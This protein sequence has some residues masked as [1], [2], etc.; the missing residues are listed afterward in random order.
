MWRGGL[1][2]AAL[3]VDVHIPMLIFSFVPIALTLWLAGKAILYEIYRRVVLRGLSSILFKSGRV[4]TLSQ[5]AADY[6]AKIEAVFVRDVIF[7]AR[8]SLWLAG[9]SIQHSATSRAEVE[10]TLPLRLNDTLEHSMRA[11]RGLA[12]WS[13]TFA[14]I[15]GGCPLAKSFL[16]KSW[17]LCRFRLSYSEVND[18]RGLDEPIIPKEEG[19]YLALLLYSLKLFTGF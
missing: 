18:T 3:E 17:W 7:R 10:N 8:I 15:L 16:G 1:L 12:W 6:R 14:T 19:V 13:P 5:S 4:W 2:T 11:G 9:S